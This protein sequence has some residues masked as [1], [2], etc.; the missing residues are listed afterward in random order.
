MTNT[1]LSSDDVKRDMIKL[2]ADAD[3]AR[4]EILGAQDAGPGAIVT[5]STAVY[6]YV[7]DDAWHRFT[8]PGR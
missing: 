8:R 6:E 5:C 4:D 3:D 7:G 1:D 2:G